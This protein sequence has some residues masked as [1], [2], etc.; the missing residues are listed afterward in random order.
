[1]SSHVRMTRKL[2]LEHEAGS[3]KRLKAG[4]CTV[5]LLLTVH[6]GLLFV[7]HTVHPCSVNVCV[8]VFRSTTYGDVG[9]CVCV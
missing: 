1:M 9:V 2:K 5:Y 4:C 8:Y 3:L 6:L 7:K